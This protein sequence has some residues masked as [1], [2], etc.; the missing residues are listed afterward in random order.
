MP[1]AYA[2]Y[3][4]ALKLLL[5]RGRSVLFLRTQ[6]GALD[7]PGGR[8]D[9]VEGKVP[10]EKILAREIREEL[11]PTLRYKL[12]P[13]LF[14]FRRWVSAFRTY[15][16]LTVY[17]GTYLAGD[18]RLSHEHRSFQWINPRQYRFHS[19]DVMSREE[20]R[21]FQRHFARRR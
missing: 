4:V 18:I 3:Q 2:H 8:I 15:N 12:G 7:L 21:A 19:A 13:P 10:L 6:S 16:L 20:Y 17:A 5:R 9:T 14:Q 1:R 11:G